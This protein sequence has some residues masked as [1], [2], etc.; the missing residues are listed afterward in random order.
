MSFWKWSKI[1]ANNATADSSCPFPEGMAPSAVNDGTRGMMAALAKWRDDIQGILISGGTGAAYAVSSNQVVTSN[2]D[3]YTVQFTPGATNTGAVT[4]SVD[5]QTAKPLRFFTGRDLPAGVLISGSLY[6][7]TYRQASDEWLLH[8]FDASVYAIP[9]GGGID[10]WGSAAPNGAFAFPA[11]QA[12]SRTA[13]ATLFSI[14]GTAHGAGDGT[15]TFNLPDKTGRVSVMKEAVATRLTA[16]YFGGNSTNIGAV[17]GDEKK[18]L[19]A[20]HIPSLTSSGNNSI[21]VT[22][23]QGGIPYNNTAGNF[24]THTGPSTGVYGP[25]RTGGTPVDIGQIT[26]S[27]NNSISVAYS[28][29]AQAP[30]PIVQPTIVCNYIIR[31]I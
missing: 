22:S 21:S 14:M 12:I 2:V 9:I 20:S 26:S 13:Y 30:V 10:Y 8:S 16:S 24:L 31:I 18:S 5:G 6:Q 29:G 7:A 1:A 3:G 25:G 15:T 27:G 19:L 28:N 11:G 4:L 17:G 23:S